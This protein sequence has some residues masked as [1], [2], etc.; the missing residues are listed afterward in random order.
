MI[1]FLS[2][3]LIISVLAAFASV[4][5]AT[6]SPMAELAGILQ[7]SLQDRHGK[8]I[9]NVRYDGQ[10]LIFVLGKGSIDQDTAEMFEAAM[11]EMDTT[12]SESLFVNSF[13][14][15][16]GADMEMILPILDKYEADIKIS[17]TL[18][19]KEYEILLPRQELS[20]K[21]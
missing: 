20:T 15:E 12:D 1:R 5:S 21:K 16:M 9:E 19:G 17:L 11:N 13:K 10:D 14:K 8:K 3:I 6:E 4:A 7:K 18:R 2:R